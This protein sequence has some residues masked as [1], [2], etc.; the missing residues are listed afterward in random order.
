MLGEINSDH[1]PD[2]FRSLSDPKLDRDIMVEMW[3][4]RDGGNQGR[5][6]TPTPRCWPIS[7]CQVCR[8]HAQGTQRARVASIGKAG[9]V[10][11]ALNPDTIKIC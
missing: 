11:P 1:N 2:L 4:L 8:G 7:S 10:G 6:G 5:P 9:R 3:E